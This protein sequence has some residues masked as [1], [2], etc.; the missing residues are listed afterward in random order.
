MDSIVHSFD[1]LAMCMEIG[2]TML[3][4][5]LA[6]AC[7]SLL[8]AKLTPFSPSHALV[9]DDEREA[10]YRETQ[11]RLAKARAKRYHT[12]PR[13]CDP[14]AET[15]PVGT[16]NTVPDLSLAETFSARAVR[17]VVVGGVTRQSVVK[18]G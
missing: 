8:A 3:G 5:V 1:V 6:V 18:V 14:D 15:R 17:M 9:H 16:D 7:G 10:F 13:V 2:L 11:A 4:T 12:Q